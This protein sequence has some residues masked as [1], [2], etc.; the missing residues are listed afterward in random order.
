MKQPLDKRTGL[1]G[2]KEKRPVI[3][4]PYNPLWVN[5]FQYHAAVIMRALGTKVIQIEHIGSTAVPKLMAKPIVDILVVLENTAEENEYLQIML[6]C[7]YSLRVREPDH[8]EHRMFRSQMRDVHIHFF[9]QRSIEIDRYLIFRS[10]LRESEE[11]RNNYQRLK[12]QLACQEWEDMNEYAQAK[13]VFIENT[14]K[15]NSKPK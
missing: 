2:A 11:I 6:E 9:S 15:E 12:Q 7:G 13:S 8:D 10:A 5:T 3:L 14:I 4:V 1:I